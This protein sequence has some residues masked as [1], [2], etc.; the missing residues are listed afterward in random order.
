MNLWEDIKVEIDAGMLL[1]EVV[2]KLQTEAGDKQPETQSTRLS[3]PPSSLLPPPSSLLPP[4]SPCGG[5]GGGGGGHKGAQ[6]ATERTR[7]GGG[8][9]REGGPNLVKE[10]L[11][12]LHQC[13]KLWRLH[14][15]MCGEGERGEE[16]G[17]RREEGEGE[18]GWVEE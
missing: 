1:R 16:G 9:S 13:F 11:I 12:P 15:H 4:P 2:P 5:G 6:R 7:R 14:L 8:A 18:R 10:H 3:D 17:G